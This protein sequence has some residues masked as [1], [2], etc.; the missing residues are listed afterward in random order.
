MAVTRRSGWFRACVQPVWGPD[1]PSRPGRA[2][3]SCPRWE[4]SK[5]NLIWTRVCSHQYHQLVQAE[6]SVY[7]V[8]YRDTWYLCPLGNPD[9][10]NNLVACAYTTGRVEIRSDGTPWRP[11]VHVRDVGSAFIAGL[12]APASLV[13]GRSYNVGIPGGNFSVRD[14][15]EAAARAVPGSTITYT[16]EHGAD[17]RTY[18]VSFA[19]ILGELSEWYCPCWSLDSGGEELVAFF[20][21]VGFGETQFRGRMT[22]RL[23]QLKQLSESARVDATLRWVL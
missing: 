17:S 9:I 3:G 20:R 7:P 13:V 15:A 14:L 19:R 18:R 2:A 4:S 12:E 6:H 21:R 16:G 22:N 11:V 10:A 5:A 1:A 23:A 8:K